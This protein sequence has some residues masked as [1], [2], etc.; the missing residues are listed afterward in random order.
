[1][2]P[3][4][5]FAVINI[6]IISEISIF[7][8]WLASECV[9]RLQPTQFGSLELTSPGYAYVIMTSRSVTDGQQNDIIVTLICVCTCVRL[10]VC[11]RELVSACSRAHVHEQT[12]HIT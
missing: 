4:A 9:P 7:S 6:G 10:C 11:T 2:V 12:Y 8:N 5:I 3:Q 1:M